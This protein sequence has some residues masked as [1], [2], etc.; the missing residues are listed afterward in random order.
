MAHAAR[1]LTAA[2]DAD[3]A[4]RQN[5][6]AFPQS[7]RRAILEWIGNA[8][9][10][11]T[12]SARIERTARDAASNNR[13]TNGASPRDPGLA[14]SVPDV[15]R[16]ND[17]SARADASPTGRTLSRRWLGLFFTAWVSR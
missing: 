5:W 16:T 1:C 15:P 13:P 9:T 2:L 6:D 3:P 7:A 14:A 11:T 17:I 8:K 12:R 10:S 4:A